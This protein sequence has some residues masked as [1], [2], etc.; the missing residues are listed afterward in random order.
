MKTLK[1]YIEIVEAAEKLKWIITLDN[2]KQLVRYGPTKQYVRDRLTTDQLLIGVK[3]I[4]QAEPDVVEEDAADDV[5]KLA[6][7]IRK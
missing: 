7:E 3:S 4:K 6:K 5:A 1:E 2:N